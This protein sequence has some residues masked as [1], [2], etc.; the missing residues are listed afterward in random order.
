MDD[1]YVIEPD[2]MARIAA[3]VRRLYSEDRMSGD[4]MRNAAQLLAVILDDCDY[5]GTAPHAT[6]D[7]R[8]RTQDRSK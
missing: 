7:A 5:N 8:L 3:V 4:D 2:R 1:Y 6:Y